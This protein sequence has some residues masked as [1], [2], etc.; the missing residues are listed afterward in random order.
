MEV[1]AVG[2]W[3]AGWQAHHPRELDDSLAGEGS[4]QINSTHTLTDWR[5]DFLTLG[6]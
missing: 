3:L 6:L 5:K 4:R 2:G 1:E